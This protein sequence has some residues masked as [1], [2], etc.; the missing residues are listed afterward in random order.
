[1]G[2]G[3]RRGWVRKAHEDSLFVA[4]L[5]EAIKSGTET[6]SIGQAERVEEALRPAERSYIS[7][8]VSNVL[9]GQLTGQRQHC[10]KFALLNLSL[11]SVP[12]S[13]ITP[14]FQRNACGA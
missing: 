14:F 6:K 10:E 12:R 2:K 3:G 11:G 13:V 5:G 8:F 7:E 4:H 9:R 1:M